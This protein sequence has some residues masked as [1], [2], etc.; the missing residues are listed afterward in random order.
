MQW[1][2]RSVH[3]VHVMRADTVVVERQRMKQKAP[4]LGGKDARKLSDDRLRLSAD[5]VTDEDYNVTRGVRYRLSGCLDFLCLDAGFLG[6][7]PVI[8]RLC[9]R[10]DNRVF[11]SRPDVKENLC[12]FT[13]ANGN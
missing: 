4:A 9:E 2:S 11:R 8:T 5:F 3:H 7:E 1:R 10:E 12:L 13:Q 6:C